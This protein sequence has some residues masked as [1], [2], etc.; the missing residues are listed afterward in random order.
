VVHLSTNK[1]S[2]G[3]NNVKPSLLPPLSGWHFRA[4]G[5]TMP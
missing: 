4:D 2:M 1:Y 3:G 5:R